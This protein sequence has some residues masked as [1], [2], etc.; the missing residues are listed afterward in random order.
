[1]T[2]QSKLGE[3]VDKMLAVGAHFGFGKGRR[4]ASTKPF[5]LINKNGTDVIDLSKTDEQ[6]KKAVAY[7]EELGKGKKV[8]LFVGTK[9]EAKIAIKDAAMS[10]DMPYVT[11]RWVGG[12]LTNWNEMKKRIARRAE[13]LKNKEKNELEK[14]T[15]KERLLLDRELDGLEVLFGG[16]ST[17]LKAPDALFVVDPRKESIAIEEASKMGIPVI[18][19]LN[20]DCSTQ[21][22]AYPIVANDASRKSVSLFVDTICAS[23]KKGQNA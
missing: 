18:S 14:Y 23:Y 13:I 22:I 1:M 20:T 15:K 9:P 8:I 21:N 17:M 12:L 6:V 2:E 3:M 19:L 10:L 4:H 16:I 7:V 11:E 5:I